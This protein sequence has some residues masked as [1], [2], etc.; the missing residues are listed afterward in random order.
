MV[1]WTDHAAQRLRQRFGLLVDDMA[2]HADKIASGAKFFGE[3]PST[4][5]VGGVYLECRW[6]DR[7]QA[8]IVVTVHGGKSPG[9]PPGARKLLA[10]H[11]KR[12]RVRVKTV[13]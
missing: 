9:V 6:N 7:Q 13:G 1:I 5:K 10:R 4:I 2:C 12:K 11:A 3:R 8:A